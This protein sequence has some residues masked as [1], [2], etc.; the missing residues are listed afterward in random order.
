MKSQLAELPDLDAYQESERNSFLETQDRLDEASEPFPIVKFSL[1]VLGQLALFLALTYWLLPRTFHSELT[2]PLRI[3]AW[4]F[5]IGLPLSL[6]EYGYHRYLLHSSV[7][8]FLSSMHRAHSLHHG[9]TYVKAA[10]TP[11]EPEKLVEV[12]SEYPIE[13]SH[14][15]EAMMFPLYTTSIFFL[16]FLALIALPIKLLFPAQPVV[17]ATLFAV[18]LQ[19]SAYEIYHAIL[20]LSYERFWQPL[21]DSKKVGKVVQYIYSFHLMH[22]WRPTSNDAVVGFWG[23]AVWDHLFGTHHRPGR[24]PLKDAHVAY[25]DAVLPKPRWPISALD[26]AQG[27]MYKSSRSLERTMARV[28]LGRKSN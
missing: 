27:G 14:Q 17:L 12:K 23:I 10:V 26:K 18:V 13:K 11:K 24:M 5:F 7:L 1:A 8:P 6:F 20:H 2:H 15:E 19:Y 22:H 16:L 3:I 9:L 4:T 28:F 21:M 25:V